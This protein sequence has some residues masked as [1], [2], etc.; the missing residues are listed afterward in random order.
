MSTDA[1]PQVII[2]KSEKSPGIA[3]IL[4]FFFGPLG[5]LYSTVKGAIIM[6][7]VNFV[8][9]LFTLGFGLFLAWP[10]CAIIGYFAA[11]KSNEKLMQA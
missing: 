2:V 1:K 7:I 3:A 5:L 4:G 8:V 10:I 6:I 11:K 9:G